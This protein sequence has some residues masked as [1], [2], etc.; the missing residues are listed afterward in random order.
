MMNYVKAK[1]IE[2]ATHWIAHE[3]HQNADK[4]ITPGKLYKLELR[5]QHWTNAWG[6]EVIN[7]DHWIKDDGNQWV[8][9]F[10]IHKGEFVK[11]VID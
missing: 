10:E 4:N 5:K 6:Q 9:I 3:D 8:R 11:E 1:D 7:E 2:S